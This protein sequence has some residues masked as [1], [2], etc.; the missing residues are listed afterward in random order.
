[1]RRFHFLL[2]L[3]AAASLAFA[4]PAG[5]LQVIVESMC[6]S[7]ASYVEGGVG[8]GNSSAK[9]NQTACSAGSRSSRDP[10]AYA[11]F[12]PTLAYEG[13]YDVYVT[14]G[15]TTASNNGPNADNVKVSII[16]QNGTQDFY[17]NMRGQAGCLNSN[18]NQLVYVGRA[19]L[20]A[21]QGHRVRITNTSNAQCFSNANRRYASADAV[22]FDYLESTPSARR[23]WGSLK[24]IYR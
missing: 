4:G 15:T 7:G 23:S 2:G 9:S 3:A 8:W 11:D 17:V 6:S 24:V 19:V 10:N 13:L 16:G 22:I 12:I 14:W 18:A 1:M 21:N 5:A 20:R